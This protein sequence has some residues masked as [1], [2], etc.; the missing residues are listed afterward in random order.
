MYSIHS[1]LGLGSKSPM[2][3]WLGIRLCI[4][5]GTKY[6]PR[7]EIEVRG[8]SWTK[9]DLPEILKW[10]QVYPKS[11]DEYRWEIIG[12]END[13]NLYREKHVVSL[14]HLN[15]IVQLLLEDI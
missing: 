1:Y 4:N 6:W 8:I 11:K 13:A 15:D 12:N 3:H 5:V 2:T 14:E 9:L 10:K 7:I